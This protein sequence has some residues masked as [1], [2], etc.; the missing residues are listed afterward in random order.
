MRYLLLCLLFFGGCG[1]HQ[2][3][4]PNIKGDQYPEPGTKFSGNLP[5]VLAKID[6]VCG[7]TWCE[8]DFGFEFMAAERAMDNVSTVVVF[9]MSLPDSPGRE[10]QAR[11]V[12]RTW[13]A[14]VHSLH[15]H[16]QVRF[17][18]AT[19]SDLDEDGE[20]NEKFYNELTDCIHWCE[21]TIQGAL[22]RPPE[23]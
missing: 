23:E 15:Q 17:W 18:T 5:K 3:E 8:G 16:W 4:G 12:T 20:L 21:E 1:L 22:R 14:S 13:S 11:H 9:N 19:N 6:A 10:L 2:L 7:D